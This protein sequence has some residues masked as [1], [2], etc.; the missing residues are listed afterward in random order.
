MAEVIAHMRERVVF[1]TRR[2]SFSGSV[3]N[4]TYGMTGGQL[5]PT[6]FRSGGLALA[7]RPG[8][9]AF[10]R[11]MVVRFQFH[12]ETEALESPETKGLTH[13]QD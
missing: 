12:Q 7:G 1:R 13:P 8:P 11:L 6:S 3:R 10:A 4:V 2:P 5:A 9:A